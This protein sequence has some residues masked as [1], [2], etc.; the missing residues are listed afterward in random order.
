MKLK[1][2]IYKALRVSND[3]NAFK[4]GKVSKRIGRRV[5][6]KSSGKLLRKLFK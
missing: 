6:G 1:N 5:T 3:I 2:L 4:K